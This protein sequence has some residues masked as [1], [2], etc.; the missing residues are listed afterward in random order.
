M[1]VHGLFGVWQVDRSALSSKKGQGTPGD[2]TQ[3]KHDI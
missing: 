3:K 2:L 1:R